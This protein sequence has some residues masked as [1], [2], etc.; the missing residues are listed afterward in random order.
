MET[1][2]TESRVRIDVSTWPVGTEFWMF[3]LPTHDLAR[4]RLATRTESGVLQLIPVNSPGTHS[5]CICEHM[6]EAIFNN[7]SLDRWQH[8][9]CSHH[10]WGDRPDPR[11]ESVGASD[12]G[13]LM[14]SLAQRWCPETQQW[15]TPPPQA[16]P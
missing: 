13:E 16:A 6:V 3:K 12:E 5:M 11:S 15:V 1:A 14:R 10:V 2:K 8:I 4:Y 9:L 7:E